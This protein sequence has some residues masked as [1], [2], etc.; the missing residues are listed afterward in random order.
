MP[1]SVSTNCCFKVLEIYSHLKDPTFIRAYRYCS[2]T[3]HFCNKTTA[4]KLEN[5]NERAIRFVFKDR[6]TT[7]EVLLAKLG[8]LTLRHE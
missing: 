1:K 3:L 7:Y 4:D 8:L 2:E 6:Y 5:V